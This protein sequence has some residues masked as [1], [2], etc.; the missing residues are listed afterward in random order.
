M[1]EAT[2]ELILLAIKAGRVAMNQVSLMNLET[3]P[4]EIRDELI[5]E[6]DALNAEW[7]KLAPRGDDGAGGTQP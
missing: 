6:R 7:A 2:V 5:R 1:D 3:L 4:P